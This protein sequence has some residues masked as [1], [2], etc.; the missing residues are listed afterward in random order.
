MKTINLFDKEM[1]IEKEYEM[2]VCVWE[3][4]G[5]NL[6]D[7]ED[8]EIKLGQK[9]YNVKILESGSIIFTISPDSKINVVTMFPQM[10]GF[11]SDEQLVE[12]KQ[13]E[14]IISKSQERINE[15]YNNIERTGYTDI[16]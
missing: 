7:Y 6:D 12:V 2:A 15:I 13:L 11:P 8:V 9:V 16:P 4:K 5:S 1:S 10:F 3:T 14:D